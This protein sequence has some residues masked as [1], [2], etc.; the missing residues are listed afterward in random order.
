[1]DEVAASG[2]VVGDHDLAGVIGVGRS[3]S[4][5]L[6]HVGS[7]LIAGD[8]VHVRAANSPVPLG[9]AQAWKTLRHCEVE[10]LRPPFDMPQ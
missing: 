6:G 2:V 1:M 5:G 4:L 9:R 8:Q 3:C 10:T 7:A